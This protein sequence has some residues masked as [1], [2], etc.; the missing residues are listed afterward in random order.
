[1][2]DEHV[3][4]S[5]AVQGGLTEEEKRSNLIRLAFDGDV[6]RYEEFCRILQTAIPPGT[7][8][9]LRGSGVTGHR[10]KVDEP[11]DADGPG[12]SDL[13]VTMV[14]EKAVGLFKLNGFFIPGVHS[15]PVSE[16]D[17]DIAPDLA[18]LREQLM[19]LVRRPV[20]IQASREIVLQVRGDLLDQP[21]LILCRKADD[22]A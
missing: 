15:R 5:V 19:G 4:R 9:V 11:F 13:D 2:A 3:G 10:W 20:N 6:N 16:D 21:Y 18:P 8:V 1:M 7:T 12:T 22:T 17:P 14:G